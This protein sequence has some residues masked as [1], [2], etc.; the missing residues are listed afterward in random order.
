MKKLS[1]VLAIAAILSG[2]GESTPVQTVEWYKEHD[3]ERRDMLTKCKSN[4]GELENSPN[5]INAQQAENEKA[6]S[7]RGL[8]PLAPIDFSKQ[9]EG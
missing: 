1:I 6:A 4:P 7:R 8:S 3:A 9:G 5:C 2:C